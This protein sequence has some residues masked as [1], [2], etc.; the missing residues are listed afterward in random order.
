MFTVHPVTNDPSQIAIEAIYGLGELVV[1]GQVNPDIYIVD[2]REL[3]IYDKTVRSQ[4]WMLIKNP[5]HG[6]PNKRE[7]VSIFLRSA[8]KLSDKDIIRLAAL[9]KQIE[10]WYEFPQDIEWAKKGEQIF[11]VQSRPI[12]TIKP[13]DGGNGQ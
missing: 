8:Q 1:S 12:T 2:K 6:A 5:G 4:E 13:Q 11:V 9:G 7:L 3:N 10:D